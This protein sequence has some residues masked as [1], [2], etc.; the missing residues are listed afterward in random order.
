M[1]QIQDELTHHFK[2]YGR[3]LI[4]LTNQT[5][6]RQMDMRD[7]KLKD[8]LASARATLKKHSLKLFTSSKT[9]IRHP[10]LSAAQSNH[11]YV[12]KELNES[13]EKIHGIITSR[14]TADNIKHL[15]DEAASLSVALDE[16]DKQ[17]VNINPAQFNE[18]E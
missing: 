4:E 9:L 16:L 13:L 11:D 8:E 10:E 5:G 14:I 17:I 2:N 12:F 1:S 7:A 3:N 15:Y 18:L 6:K